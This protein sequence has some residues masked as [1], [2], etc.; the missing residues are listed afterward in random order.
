M[1]MLA[2]LVAT[3]YYIYGFCSVLPP[4]VKTLAQFP[5]SYHFLF[6]FLSSGLQVC[7]SLS[8]L[9]L[10]DWRGYIRDWSAVI[11]RAHIDNLPFIITITPLENLDSL[12]QWHSHHFRNGGNGITV[13]KEDNLL[14]ISK[15]LS[16]HIQLFCIVA[17]ELIVS[18][19]CPMANAE[20]K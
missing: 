12:I 7:W 6:Q 20:V 8:Q 2:Y 9:S 10:G 4:P 18:V 15:W 5:S 11:H 16:S 1:L 3:S 14:C 19:K 17:Q 13:T